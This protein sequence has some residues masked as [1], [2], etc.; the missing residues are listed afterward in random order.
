[1]VSNISAHFCEIPRNFIGI[2]AD[3]R[4]AEAIAA[5]RCATIYVHYVVNKRAS[6]D[7]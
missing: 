7:D 3:D 6:G 1:M 2:V 4:L 5:A